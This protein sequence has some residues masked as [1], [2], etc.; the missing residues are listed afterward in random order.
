MPIETR[1]ICLQTNSFKLEDPRY[2]CL[3]VEVHMPLFRWDVGLAQMP[4]DPPLP[5]SLTPG[6]GGDE[7][8]ALKGPACGGPCPPCPNT[9][10]L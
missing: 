5:C 7:G 3:Q 1:Q 4:H 2:A 6:A 9:P 8:Q 10:F